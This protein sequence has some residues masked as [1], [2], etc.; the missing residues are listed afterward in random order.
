MSKRA[1]GHNQS[2]TEAIRF[3]ARVVWRSARRP[4]QLVFVLQFLSTGLSAL[5]LYLLARLVE[6]VSVGERADLLSEL[7]PEILLYGLTLVSIGWSGNLADEAELY[8]M[9]LVRRDS[10]LIVAD[11]AA[12]TKFEKFED[13]DFHDRL[14]RANASSGS[15]LYNLVFGTISLLSSSMYFVAVAIVLALLS[16]A[17]LLIAAFAA[18]P[19][20]VSS[21]INT[22]R[23]YKYTYELTEDDRRRRYLHSTLLSRLAAPELNTL[24]AR[25]NIRRRIDHL[26]DDR[27][28][29]T[30]RLIHDRI[31][32]MF[33]SIFVS[34][35]IGTTA[36]AVLIRQIGTGAL[37]LSE[38]A[39]ALVALQQVRRQ[40]NGMAKTVADIHESAA[41]VGDASEFL[42]NDLEASDPIAPEL[43][44][45]KRIR[46]E[47]VTFTY[48]GTA[49]AAVDQVT[50]EIA[51]GEVVAVVGEN[52]SGKTTLARLLAGLYEPHDG[53]IT[54][55][56][57]VIAPGTM[58]RVAPV[59]QRFNRYALS[60]M[61]NITLGDP[62]K[63]EDRARA[64]AAAAAAGIAEKLESL[65]RQYDTQ[66][67][68]EFENGVDLS[69]GEW[70]RL[71]IAR[72]LYREAPF[73]I[74]DEPTASID[75]R[76]ETELFAALRS[77][78]RDKAVLLISH[79]FS[80]V[81][82]AN[83]IVVL[84][85]GSVEETGTHDEL[86][87]NGARYAELFRLQASP[88]FD[89]QGS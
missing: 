12:R 30:L 52:G 34:A 74:L 70:Q 44:V 43:P 84:H 38:A 2:T 88:Y 62:D 53:E 67:A 14:A 66:L 1:L 75:A 16:P 39:V 86:M 18:I 89:E 47:S 4:S 40:S 37:S 76:A 13:P 3:A 6:A 27:I 19:I 72:A 81:R 71:A 15:A 42:V 25:A 32:I 69:G 87:A 78:A 31:P 23:L 68:R 83:R 49:R 58:P 77:L 17:V 8:A 48:P 61:E 73:V 24:G 41:F 50:I 82:D 22:K 28:H 60:A 56:D 63:P 80:T 54:W 10:S 46:A 45:L 65:P 7:T 33:T 26:F 20:V 29:R 64:K 59:F 35:A 57:V 55:N 85:N 21:R 51:A 79:R 9:D 11:T 36:A 5:Q